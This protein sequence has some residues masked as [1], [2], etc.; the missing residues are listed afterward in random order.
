M[1]LD[2]LKIMWEY[3]TLANFDWEESPGSLDDGD[4][5]RLDDF[6][7]LM[8]FYLQ[9][10]TLKV[11]QD[12]TIMALFNYFVNRDMILVATLM[13]ANSNNEQEEINTLLQ[14]EDKKQNKW[15]LCYM[16]MMN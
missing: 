12:E 1:G 10:K 3:F 13:Q 8:D 5:M 2:N 4:R 14:I 11:R 15:E 16:H 7:E 9:H 6:K